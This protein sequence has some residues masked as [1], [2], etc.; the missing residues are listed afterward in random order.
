[1]S[2]SI[3]MLSIQIN[4]KRFEMVIHHQQYQFVLLCKPYEREFSNR[5]CKVIR[6][7]KVDKKAAFHRHGIK[8]SLRL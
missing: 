2:P 3:L 5:C 8:S 4:T 7:S 6:C 1:M